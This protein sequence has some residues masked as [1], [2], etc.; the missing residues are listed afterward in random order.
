MIGLDR[1]IT[2]TLVLL[3]L[4]GAAL[5]SH[6]Q[7]PEIEEQPEKTSYNVTLG[8]LAAKDSSLPVETFMV[9]L[10]T[11]DINR[12]CMEN[13]APWRFNFR[14]RYAEGQSQRA[15]EMTQLY[16]DEGI[17]LV[18]GYQWSS[19]LCSGSRKI[20]AENNMTL[21]SVGSTSP[22]LIMEDNVFRLSLNDLRLV[23]PVTALMDEFGYDSVV[24]IQRGDA[25][26]DNIVKAFTEVYNGEIIGTIRYP[27]DTQKDFT[28]Y[29]DKADTLIREGDNATCVILVTFTEAKR[30]LNQTTDYP[31]LLNRTWFG[32]DG[33]ANIHNLE[34][35]AAMV[36][37]TIGLYSPFITPYPENERYQ[38]INTRYRDKYNGNMTHFEAN[39]YD[40]CWLMAHLVLDANTTDAPT[41]LDSINETSRNHMGITGDMSLDENGDRLN[42][43]YAVYGYILDDGVCNPELLGYYLPATSEI[44]WKEEAT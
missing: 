29:L 37:S 28:H 11:E 14:I 4:L 26:A 20:A 32:T 5:L 3:G 39:V 22:L 43:P 1:R 24:I 38:E 36:A 2:L 31:M 23:D 9:S 7:E 18:G 25:W 21:I 34:G 17:M 41:I 42:Y 15:F 16:A 6:Q 19:F 10:A 13:G 33:T 35:E 12:Y 44:M 27:G 8:Y 30:L 40:C